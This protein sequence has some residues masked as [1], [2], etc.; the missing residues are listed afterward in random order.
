MKNNA[1][2][3]KQAACKSELVIH[4]A[5][6]PIHRLPPL[7][8][9][10]DAA[11]GA[12]RAAA[13]FALFG[14]GGAGGARSAVPRSILPVVFAWILR[15]AVPSR[16]ALRRAGGAAEFSVVYTSSGVVLLYLSCRRSTLLP[17]RPLAS[18]GAMRVQSPDDRHGFGIALRSGP[19]CNDNTADLPRSG[20]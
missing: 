2:T 12:T 16:G 10:P 11:G 18:Q 1:S 4:G 8:F 5:K 13:H 20:R 6:C 14:R 19:G 15:F 3:T 9:L 17:D 7:E